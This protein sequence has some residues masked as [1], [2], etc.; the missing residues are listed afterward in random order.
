MPGEVWAYAGFTFN[1]L[2]ATASHVFVADPLSEILPPVVLLGLGGAS[3]FL[4]PDAR[5]LPRETA[6]AGGSLRQPS[7]S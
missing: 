3:Y 7:P 2:G 4:R 5:R 1:L 6:T